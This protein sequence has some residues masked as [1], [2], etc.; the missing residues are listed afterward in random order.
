MLLI[1]FPVLFGF[2]KK[3]KPNSAF[4][5]LLIWLL[6]F[7]FAAVAQLEF[8]VKEN[9]E[10]Y[11]CPAPLLER[12]H[13]HKIAP[14][15]TV[16]TIA[17]QYN[18]LPDTLIRLNDS[19]AAGN[20]PVGTQILIPPFNGI[21]LEV[22]SGASWKD[23]EAAYGV[24]AG[25]LFEINGCQRTPPKVVFLPGV[26]WHPTGGSQ[27]ENYIG[28]SGY[29]L[30]NVAKVELSYGWQENHT[31]QQRMFHP[32]ID[33]LAELGTTVLSA[34]TGIVAFVGKQ[35]SYGNLVII[36]HPGG[37]QTR[38]GHL[39]TIKVKIGQQVRVGDTIGTV[40]KSGIPDLHQPHLQFEIRRKNHLGWVAQD[41]Q[42][43]LQIEEK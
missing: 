17:T 25:V 8:K 7:P 18:L 28:L 11:K 21:S 27:P 32:G 31:R 23:L 5:P 35:K 16:E 33:L 39:A 29:P 9:L 41:P 13:P 40:G 15:E 22:P 36:N 42:N 43:H 37:W 34:E 1:V 30:P 4:L 3:V 19:L 20:A 24:G 6:G 10:Q 12:L 14:G 2:S 26:N 38:Y